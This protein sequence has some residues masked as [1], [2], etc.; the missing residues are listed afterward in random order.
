MKLIALTS[1]FAFFASN[2]S[3]FAPQPRAITPVI[4]MSQQRTVLFMAEEKSLEE[5]VEEMVSEEVNKSKRMSNMRNEKGVEYAP[6][7]NM[8]KEDEERIRNV[9]RE[10]AETRRKRRAEQSDVQGELMR[11]FGFQELSG[12]GL[13]SKVLEGGNVELEWTTG[14]EANTKGFM[15]KRRAAK[16]EKFEVLATY[17]SYGPLESQGPQGGTYRYF[18]DKVDAGSYVYRVT[19]C[20]ASGTENDLSQCLVDVETVEEQRGTLIAAAGI[21]AI[22]IAAGFA[23]VLLDPVQY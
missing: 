2:A 13:R 18:D 3:A 7:M 1:T 20:D 4:G 19:E 16:T 15:V 22:L 23:G 10:K 12:T 11:D 21:F 8:S 9:M 17:E 14:E 6:W 5:E